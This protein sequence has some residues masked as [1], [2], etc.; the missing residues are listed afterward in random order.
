ML[1]N[2]LQ[3]IEYKIQTFNPTSTIWFIKYK[4]KTWI[5][6]FMKYS[7]KDKENRIYKLRMWWVKYRIIIIK[8]ID[9][10]ET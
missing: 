6:I 10:Y 3:S 1:W 7:I 4:V 8:Y 9:I 5:N 2:N